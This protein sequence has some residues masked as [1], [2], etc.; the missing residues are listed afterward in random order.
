MSLWPI[1][2]CT[3]RK[4]TPA[5]RCHVA[6]VDLN[7]CSQ[8]SLGFNFARSATALRSSRKFILGLQP[9]VGNTSPQVLSDFAFHAF[10]RRTS[11]SGSESPA[12]YTPSESSLYLACVSFSRPH[13]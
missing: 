12:P 1:Q 7:L 11:L 6:N 9:A 10:N 5:Q 8:K 4:S 13:D 3:V 2:C